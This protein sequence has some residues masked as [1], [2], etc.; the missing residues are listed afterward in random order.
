MVL[1]PV[2]FP[3]LFP[4]RMPRPH[5]EWPLGQVPR[6]LTCKILSMVARPVLN[7]RPPPLLPHPVINEVELVARVAFL[8]HRSVCLHAVLR[9]VVKA[10]V[11]SAAWH[12]AVAAIMFCTPT[13]QA[14]RSSSW[15]NDQLSAAFQADFVLQ[16]L[17]SAVICDGD[18]HCRCIEFN[19]L[20]TPFPKKQNLRADVADVSV[21]FISLFTLEL[22][23]L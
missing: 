5:P 4:Y 21:A 18:S 17:D 9:L 8:C 15:D 16:A 20:K 22:G 14:K 19:R 6:E 13:T 2:A 1:V 23:A 3:R 10:V 12:A 7:V 11:V